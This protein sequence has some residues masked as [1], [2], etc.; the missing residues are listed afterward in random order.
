MEKHIALPNCWFK[1]E[2]DLVKL[3]EKLSFFKGLWFDIYNELQ[4]HWDLEDEM[5]KINRDITEG[6]HEFC[7]IVNQYKEVSYTI[8]C[9]TKI[10]HQYFMNEQTIQFLDILRSIKVHVM[11]TVKISKEL[12]R[13]FD[14]ISFTL[15]NTIISVKDL[16]DKALAGDKYDEPKHDENDEDNDPKH[17]EHDDP[18]QDE[19]YVHDDPKRDEN[20]EHDDPKY[21]KN[22]EH[23]DPKHDENDEPD[24]PNYDEND[25]HDEPKH[26]ENDEHDDDPKQDENYVYDDPKH[27]EN[28]E[29][30]DPKYDKNDEYNDAKHD[31]NDEHDDPKEDENDEPKCDENDEHDGPKYDVHGKPKH[32]CNYETSLAICNSFKESERLK[33]QKQE[34]IDKEKKDLETAR[35]E[36]K[37]IVMR[38]NDQIKQSTEK[39]TELQKEQENHVSNSSKCSGEWFWT[40]FTRT[41]SDDD[42]K[43][44]KRSKDIETF[45]TKINHYQIEIGKAT[46]DYD[47][48]KTKIKQNTEDEIAKIDYSRDEITQLMNESDKEE[49]IPDFSDKVTEKEY[50]MEHESRCNLQVIIPSRNTPQRVDYP[51][52]K[53][54]KSFKNLYSFLCDIQPPLNKI[55]CHWD[56]IFQ[57]MCK[58]HDDI[59]HL[60]YDE[61]TASVFENKALRDNCDCLNKDFTRI[62]YSSQNVFYVNESARVNGLGN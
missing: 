46:N 14:N 60:I 3:T 58:I 21:D 20:D 30:D 37:D 9:K 34:I 1:D 44:T 40:F 11:E 39:L 41:T 12:Q 23:N 19:E 48:K 59:K 16:H 53:A 38:L 57:T 33:K 4:E 49:T 47:E 55:N 61:K 25:E 7:F 13:K 62:F 35:S 22:D 32:H 15:Q 42:D 45:Q 5:C 10:A 51:Y 8:C 26:D 31:E 24:E 43:A 54:I 29:H 36:F 2:M 18:K 6:I 17:D 27:D 28:D 50:L 52:E 56:K